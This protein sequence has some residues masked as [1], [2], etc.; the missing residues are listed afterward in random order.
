VG[1]VGVAA[2]I[3]GTVLYLTAP[4][5]RPVIE[6]ARLEV[7]RSAGLQVSFAARF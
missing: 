4:V 1:S 7:D 3:A 6:H 5:A 2:L